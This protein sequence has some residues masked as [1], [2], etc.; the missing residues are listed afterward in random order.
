VVRRSAVVIGFIVIGF[1]VI[2][3]IV[4]GFIVIG[5]IVIGFIV[6]QSLANQ[7]R[8]AMPVQAGY[9]LAKNGERNRKA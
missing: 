1:I 8:E 6:M 7:R 4:I 9:S 2:G 5:F 3:F